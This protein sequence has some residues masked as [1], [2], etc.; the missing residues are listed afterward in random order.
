M[1]TKIPSIRA[2]MMAAALAILSP[3]AAATLITSDSVLEI[4]L[5]TDFYTALVGPLE[6]LDRDWGGSTR[7]T[8]PRGSDNPDGTPSLYLE[9]FGQVMSIPGGN[10]IFEHAQFYVSQPLVCLFTGH[11]SVMNRLSAADEV[12]SRA[13]AVGFSVTDVTDNEVLASFNINQYGPGTRAGDFSVSFNLEPNHEY[14]FGAG[15]S[16]FDASYLQVLHL[17]ESGGMVWCTALAWIGLF[18]VRKSAGV[19]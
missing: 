3:H 11:Y 13:P 1:K 17:P 10:F 16:A 2:A 8:P 12:A 18:L 6:F 5:P 7:D 19:K 9:S 4:T 14:D 15:S